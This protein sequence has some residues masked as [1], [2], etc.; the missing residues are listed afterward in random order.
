MREAILL[1]PEILDDS[2]H[3]DV[4]KSL[5]ELIEQHKELT[6][7]ALDVMSNLH[8][9]SATVND[10]IAFAL[11]LLDSADELD[12]PAV[13]R[14]LLHMPSGSST[15]VIVENLRQSLSTLTVSSTSRT[16]PSQRATNSVQVC[17]SHRPGANQSMATLLVL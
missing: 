11:R 5:V 9:D 15:K 12:L 17:H 13:V 1:I 2:T 16:G 6:V 14:F 7:S 3:S 10:L 4:V 8:T